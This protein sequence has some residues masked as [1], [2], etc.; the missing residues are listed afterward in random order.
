MCL[1]ISPVALLFLFLVLVTFAL[2]EL[3]KKSIA[4]L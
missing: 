4:H 3:L 2:N 1:V